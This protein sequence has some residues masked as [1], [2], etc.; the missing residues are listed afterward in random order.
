M[1]I[2]SDVAITF[3]EID[4]KGK[5]RRE[6][7]LNLGRGWRGAGWFSLFSNPAP[8]LMTRIQREDQREGLPPSTVSLIQAPRTNRTGTVLDQEKDI[9]T[10]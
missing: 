9:A 5:A 7:E 10:I 2:D 4:E 8:W 3:T 1:W 6:H